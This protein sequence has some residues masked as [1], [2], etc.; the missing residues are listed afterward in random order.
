MRRIAL[1]L[2]CA[3]AVLAAGCGGAKKNEIQITADGDGFT[4]A[5]V[6]VPAGQPV[7]LVFKR[8]TDAT[9]ATEA[10]FAANGERLG[11]PLGQ[12]VRITVT[13]AAGETLHYACGMN[14]YLGQIVA[15]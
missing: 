15:K 7:T 14:M 5:S 12:E 1:A 4:P 10:V 2:M 6:E 8:T 11:L 13:P 3:A 9:C